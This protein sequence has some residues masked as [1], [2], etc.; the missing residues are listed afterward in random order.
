MAFCWY[1]HIQV[2]HDL[3]RLMIRE[4]KAYR[5]PRLPRQE[6]PATMNVQ[7]FELMLVCS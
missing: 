7:F 3:D 2:S 6:E 5:A 1:V 4:S